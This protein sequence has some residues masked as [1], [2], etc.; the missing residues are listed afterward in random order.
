M[1]EHQ[2]FVSPPAQS[3]GERYTT[4]FG[5]DDPDRK[6]YVQKLLTSLS[7][8]DLATFTYD[9]VRELAANRTVIFITHRLGSTQHA[10][11]I[12]VLDHGR[13]FEQ[14]D[15]ASLLAADGEYAA[16]WT[17][18]ARAYTPTPVP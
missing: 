3:T 11:R 15:H 13:I 12:I 1:H 4:W 17:T 10:D 8:N 6:A 18:R 5:A 2:Y 9:R 7:N 16:M 14:G